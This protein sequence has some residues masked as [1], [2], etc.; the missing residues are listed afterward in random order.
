MPKVTKLLSIRTGMRTP[1]ALHQSPVLTRSYCTGP[2]RELS[3][4]ILL[5]R[6]ACGDHVVCPRTGASSAQ[7]TSNESHSLRQEWC[8]A[9][10]PRALPP[11]PHR[12]IC[13]GEGS[14][15]SRA[16]YIS[17][18]KVS[19]PF[20]FFVSSLSEARSVQKQITPPFL[21]PCRSPHL[22]EAQAWKRGERRRLDR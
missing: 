12:P 21:S 13:E 9:N 1:A 3:Y 16:S 15:P 11:R 8:G 4:R 17:N 10:S 14:F 5:P 2:V 20:A 22:G 19:D 6:P 18:S 7:E